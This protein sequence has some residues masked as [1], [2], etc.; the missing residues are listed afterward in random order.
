MDPDLFGEIAVSQDDVELWLNA[1]TNLSGS[2]WRRV[3]YAQA[4]N[5]V[6]KV[7]AAKAAGQWPPSKGELT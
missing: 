6:E 1:V 7:R 5:V 3:A 4:W 2:P